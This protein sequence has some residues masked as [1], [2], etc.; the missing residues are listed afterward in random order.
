MVYRH[1]NAVTTEEAY[2]I[3]QIQEFFATIRQAQFSFKPHPISGYWQIPDIKEEWL[4][5]AFFTLH[6]YWMIV[7][8]IV[9]INLDNIL[10]YLDN[11]V[12]FSATISTLRCCIG[13]AAPVWAEAQI[14]KYDL[15]KC[16]I[17]FS[18]DFS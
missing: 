17:K 16:E 12:V 7:S 2:P 15:F 5:I 9:D 6:F 10:I 3:P 13:P 8:C 11:E 4:K 1:L 14:Q 18:N